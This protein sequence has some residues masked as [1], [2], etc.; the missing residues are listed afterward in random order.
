MNLED[1]FFGCQVNA[2]VDV[3][4]LFEISKLC[5]GVAHC[6]G[7]SDEDNSRFKCSSKYHYIP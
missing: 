1:G 6:F 2:S 4:Q 5:D 7:G 3:L